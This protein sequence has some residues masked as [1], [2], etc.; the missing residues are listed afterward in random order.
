MQGPELGVQADDIDFPEPEQEAK[1]EVLENK[2]VC[3]SFLFFPH[4]EAINLSLHKHL[5][6]H[7]LKYLMI[8][9]LV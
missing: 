1:Q 8:N 5:F 9:A 3:V 6:Q 2:D 4:Y 7:V